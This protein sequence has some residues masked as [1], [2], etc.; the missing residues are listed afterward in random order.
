[1]LKNLIP[2]EVKTEVYYELCFD[3]GHN[4][5]FGFPCEADGRLL[6]MSADAKRNLEW[7]KAHPERFKRFDEVVGFENTFREPAH[8]TCICG[9]DVLLEDQYY[10]ACQCPNCGRWYNLFGQ[11]LLDPSQWELDP[12]EKDE[13]P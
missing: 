11:S 12:A 10:G 4:N 9:E 5:G 6:E 1:M 2:A 13:E 3:D 7:C 8:G